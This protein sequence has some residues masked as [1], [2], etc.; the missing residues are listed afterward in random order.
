VARFF[1]PTNPPAPGWPQ[2]YALAVPTKHRTPLPPRIPESLDTSMDGPLSDDR[3][4]ARAFVS[5]DFSAQ[6]AAGVTLEQCRVADAQ[7]T[8]ASLDRL[9]L[10]DVV[11]ERSDLSGADVDQANLLRVEFRDCRM[12]G[13]LF[14]RARLGEVSITRCRLD[15]ASF[16]MSEARSVAFD[17]DDLRSVDF[18][19]S[20]LLD[21]RIFD[22]DLTGA[23]FSKASAPGLR[24]H[25]STL[26][27]VKGSDALS[28]AVIESS[29]VLAVA[30][31]VLSALRIEVDDDREGTAG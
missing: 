2:S 3:T 22:C 19:A 14:T 1:D 16:R 26:Y 24:L 18:Y 23:E 13:A 29:Q 17:A 27:D 21:T 20:K 31:G 9:R 15:G 10:T 30:L 25:G 28:G 12:S 8:G 4:I 7:F 6:T 11:V 5:G